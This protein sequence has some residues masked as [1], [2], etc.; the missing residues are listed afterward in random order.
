[1]REATAIRTRHGIVTL[2]MPLL[3]AKPILLVLL[4]ALVSF[5]VSSS[6][7]SAIRGCSVS[8]VELYVEKVFFIS[9]GDVGA[10]AFY[11]MLAST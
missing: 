6:A 9:G 10:G 2:R 11:S 4:L 8:F 1:M 5:A 3:A 7:F